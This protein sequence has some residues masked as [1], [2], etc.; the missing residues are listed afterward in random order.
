MSTSVYVGSRATAFG[1]SRL[2]GVKRSTVSSY[3]AKG[4]TGAV[5]RKE[6]IHPEWFPEAPVTCGGVEV[7]KV[8]GTKPSYNVEVY[9]GNH[10]FFMGKGGGQLIM[11]NKQLNKFRNMWN[12]DELNTIAPA[13]AKAI[14]EKVEKKKKGKR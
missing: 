9:S 13:S 8:G 10:P 3:N 11:D 14:V 1:G 5:M 12:D 7:L 6:G 4:A 2:Q